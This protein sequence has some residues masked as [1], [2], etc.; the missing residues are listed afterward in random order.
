MAAGDASRSDRDGRGWRVG[1]TLHEKLVAYYTQYYRDTLAIPDWRAHV[2]KASEIEPLIDFSRWFLLFPGAG[3][4]PVLDVGCGTGRT[5]AA[6]GSRSITVAGIDSDI[7][8]VALANERMTHIGGMLG[9]YGYAIR[10]RAE[11]IEFADETFDM[12]Y[13]QSV[14]EHVYSPA[15]VVSEVHRVLRPGGQF[16]LFTPNKMAFWESHYKIPFVNWLPMWLKRW[17]LRRMGRPDQFITMVQCLSRRQCR[18]L[19]EQHG[20]EIVSDTNPDRSRRLGGRL[21]GVLVL[22]HRLLGI[23]PTVYL[24]GRKRKEEEGPW[25]TPLHGAEESIPVA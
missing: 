1:L 21:G 6:W 3:T 10:C 20:F 4:I 13:S 12:V 17:L 11:A 9:G 15:L 23:H 22:L 19:L 16:H 18:R 5:M 8:A 24:V 7:T 25:Q 2:Q 14:L